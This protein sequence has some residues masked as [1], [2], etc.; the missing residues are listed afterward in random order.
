MD[1]RDQAAIAA[2]TAVIADRPPLP[3]RMAVRALVRCVLTTVVLLGRHAISQPVSMSD[4]S[5][6]SRTGHERVCTEKRS[7]RAHDP[8]RQ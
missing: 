5:S 4:P 1:R 3:L 8:M 7:S 6:A 2:Q